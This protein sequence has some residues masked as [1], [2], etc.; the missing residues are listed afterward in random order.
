MDVYSEIAQKIIAEQETIIGPVAVEKAKEVVGLKVDWKNKTVVIT[1]E[2]KKIIDNLVVVY[3]ELFGQISVEVCKDAL[4]KI[5]E[6]LSP[7]Q[8]PAS[9]R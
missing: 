4:R 9:L 5:P 2:P 1:G 3:K 6:N 7:E 8:V